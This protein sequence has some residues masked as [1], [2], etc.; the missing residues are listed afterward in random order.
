MSQ[1]IISPKLAVAL[2]LTGILSG[3]NT[4]VAKEREW[5]IKSNDT[6]SKIVERY[7]PSIRNKK[8][9]IRAIVQDNP[10]AFRRGN[11]HDLILGK[12]LILPEPDRFKNTTTKA[13]TDSTASDASK[14][15]EP[16]AVVEPVNEAPETVAESTSAEAP[17]TNKSAS[18]V[19]SNVKENI[20]ELEEGRKE[21]EETLKLVE[22]EN[23]SLQSM[24][25]KYEEQKHAQDAQIAK[26]E[27]QVKQLEANLKNTDSTKAVTPAPAVAP[28]AA[29]SE[30]S[31]A[32]SKQLAEKERVTETLKTQLAETKRQNDALQEELQ[33]KITTMESN[34]SNNLPW[35]ISALLA[36]VMLPLLWLLKQKMQALPTV[37]VANQALKK[38]PVAKPVTQAAAPKVADPLPT[39]TIT[40]STATVTPVVS[41]ARADDH[42]DDNLEADIKLDMARAYMDLRNASAAAEILQDVLVEGGARQRQEAREIL[43]FI[44]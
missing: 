20:D 38:E 7:Y 8:A 21:L 42:S 16:V 27:D 26:L 3:V 36:L 25:G 10:N 43:S 41:N 28:V 6:L 37:S 17:A 2:V 22:E 30:D 24:V 4:S 35:I 34:S 40:T 31:A 1:K 11:A 18:N 15:V 5:V 23:A 14:V 9:V 33:T 12:V 13:E 29:A 44:S 19:P 32:I 39:A